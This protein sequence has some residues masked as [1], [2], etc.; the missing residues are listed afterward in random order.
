MSL[1]LTLVLEVGF[2]LFAGRLF[3]TGKRSKKDLLLVIMVNVLTNPVVVLSYWLSFYY[4]NWNLTLVKIP[5]EAFAVLVEWWYY[6]KY[7]EGFR[8]PFFFSLS[9][10]AFSFFTGL[11]IQGVF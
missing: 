7:G 10:N 4:T 5:L 11:L 1:V 6:R 3:T 8:R 2:F 9:A